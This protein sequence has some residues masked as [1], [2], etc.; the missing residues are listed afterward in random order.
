MN[1][2]FINAFQFI[3]IIQIILSIT[4]EGNIKHIIESELLKG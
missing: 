3:L 4:D 2:L 1:P